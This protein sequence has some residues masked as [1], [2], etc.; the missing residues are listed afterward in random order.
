[1]GKKR[2]RHILILFIIAGCSIPKSK[3]IELLEAV[4]QNTSLVIQVNDTMDLDMDPQ[5]FKSIDYSYELSYKPRLGLS[6]MYAMT[7]SCL[8]L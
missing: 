1:M 3:D 7:A 4:P 6:S 2:H 8:A 5:S